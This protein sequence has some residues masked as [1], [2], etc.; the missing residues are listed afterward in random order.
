MTFEIIN[1]AVN[2]IHNDCFDLSILNNDTKEVVIFD[3][4]KIWDEDQ[5]SLKDM[6]Y[7][8]ESLDA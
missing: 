4:V 6:F 1:V 7:Y 8:D 5:Q 3:C 2:A